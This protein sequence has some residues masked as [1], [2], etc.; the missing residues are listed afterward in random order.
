[1]LVILQRN[2]GDHGLH[3]QTHTHT[4]THMVV[5]AIFVRTIKHISVTDVDT[6][7]AKLKQN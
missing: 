4:H 5:A 2:T 6:H 1:M 3:S 7:T